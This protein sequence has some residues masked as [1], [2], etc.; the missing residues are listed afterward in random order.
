MF[1]S[2]SYGR[3]SDPRWHP[4][5]MLLLSDVCFPGPKHVYHTWAG[6]HLT[7]QFNPSK[8]VVFFFCSTNVPH[9]GYTEILQWFLGKKKN[10][11]FTSTGQ[12]NSWADSAFSSWYLAT[13]M[14]GNTRLHRCL[15]FFGQ[16]PKKISTGSIM[17]IIMD[18]MD[19]SI[20]IIS[21]G[22]LLYRITCHLH[23]PWSESSWAGQGQSLQ[24]HCGRLLKRILK[25]AGL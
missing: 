11:F 16:G 1:V 23:W 4:T 15:A 2:P 5:G 20:S 6:G 17:G 13:E 25:T 19:L 21:V 3:H 7:L 8:L 9:A 24:L 14:L 12:G 10:I 22:I 18:Q